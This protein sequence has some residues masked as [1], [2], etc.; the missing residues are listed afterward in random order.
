MP[1]GDRTGPNGAGSMT[2]RGAGL[3][4]GNTTGGFTSS[5]AGMGAGNRAGRGMGMNQNSGLGTGIRGGRNYNRAGMAAPEAPAD[6]STG[7][8]QQMD[9]MQKQ[10]NT[11]ATSIKNLL[12]K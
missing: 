9:T 4:G 5:G 7:L 6:N 10:L 8:Q 2:G 11:I 1:R 3:C 12:S